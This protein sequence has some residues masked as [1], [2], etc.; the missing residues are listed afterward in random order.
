MVER[1][2]SMMG[3]K[4][5]RNRPLEG[6]AKEL[7]ISYST[8]GGR[9]ANILESARISTVCISKSAQPASFCAAHHLAS[10]DQLSL[11]L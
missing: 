8:F 1:V 10:R 2:R 7:K 4:K 6:F 5:T 9:F 11:R 3:A